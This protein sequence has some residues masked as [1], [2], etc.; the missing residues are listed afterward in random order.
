MALLYNQYRIMSIIFAEITRVFQF[1]ICDR[2]GH[3]WL[4]LYML[5]IATSYRI[6]ETERTFKTEYVISQSIIMVCKK[7]DILFNC[8]IIKQTRHFVS[9]GL[10]Y[11][12]PSDWFLIFI[13]SFKK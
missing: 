10:Y 12:S 8:M 13:M 9:A 6:E 7:W 3:C 4:K 1:S 2:I 5:S 11:C